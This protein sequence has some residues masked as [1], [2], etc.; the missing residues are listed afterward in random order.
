MGNLRL[1]PPLPM[2]PEALHGSADRGGDRA[3]TSGSIADGRS[4]AAA[5]ARVRRPDAQPRRRRSRTWRTRRCS[6]PRSRT[7][8]TTTGSR[9]SSVRSPTTSSTWWSST[10]ARSRRRSRRSR[11]SPSAAPWRG[12]PRTPRRSRTATRRTTSTSRARGCPTTPSPSATSNGCANFFAALEPFSRGVY[13]NFTNEDS[14]TASGPAPTVAAQ[15]Q[16]LVDLKAKFDPT[17]F[18][19]GNANIPPALDRRELAT[20]GLVHDSLGHLDAPVRSG[21]LVVGAHAHRANDRSCDLE[22]EDPVVTRFTTSRAVTDPCWP[23]P[24]SASSGHRRSR[25]RRRPVPPTGWSP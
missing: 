23:R 14:T 24:R 9:T 8:A 15:W 6:T 19:R 17:N 12:C 10:R 5:D 18:F 11:S 21:E 2:I 25:R 13:V 20:H 4:R 22:P 16:R 1:A 3:P 7:G